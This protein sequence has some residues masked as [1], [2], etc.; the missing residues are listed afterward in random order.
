MKPLLILT[1]Y[2]WAIYSNLSIGCGLQN[3]LL[4]NWKNE[5]NAKVISLNCDNDIAKITTYHITPISVV[6]Q[7]SPAVLTE[8][9]LLSIHLNSDGSLTIGDDFYYKYND[10][11][12]EHPTT[13]ANGVQTCSV[14]TSYFKQHYPF[15]KLHE[16][17][18]KD[19][20]KKCAMAPND[21]DALFTY[22]SGMLAEIGD[23]HLM[24]VQRLAGSGKSY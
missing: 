24:L 10:E 8:E 5:I 19:W 21:N 2:L 3:D 17:N 15:F 18:Y 9:D 22:L 7:S 14:M 4:G 16:I 12:Q 23:N 6:A 20:S 1:F 11:M 13:S